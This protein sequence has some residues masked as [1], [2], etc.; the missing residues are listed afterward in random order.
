MCQPAVVVGPG[1]HTVG[2]VP[3]VGL[4]FDSPLPALPPVVG[5]AQQTPDCL[6]ICER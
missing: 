1:S 5:R 4:G 6:Q 3:E 2:G